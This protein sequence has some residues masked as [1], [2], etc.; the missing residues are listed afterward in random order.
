MPVP[1]LL[2]RE[3]VVDLSDAAA[4]HVLTLQA[5]HAS[6]Q[7]QRHYLF[8]CRQ[9]IDGFASMGI[10][11]DPMNLTTTNMRS[12]LAWYR[13]HVNQH[14]SRGGEVSVKIFAMRAKTFS[15]F[16]AR[17]QIIPDDLLR[18]LR[19]PRV[20]KILREPFTQTE[21][22][23]MWGACRGVTQPE[24][25]E[26]LFLLLLD[27]G[28]RIGEAASL[29][30]D[31]LR[32]DQRQV[33]VGADGKGRRERLVPIGDGSKRDGGRVLRALRNYL[34]VRKP[35]EP[36]TGRLFLSR[37]GRPMSA[38]AAS[39]AIQRLGELAGVHNPIPYRLRHTFCTWY[40]VAFPGDEIGLRQ[41]VGHL[42]HDVLA[43][44]V[45]Y[46]H[47]VIAD[48]AGRASLAEA[49]LGA[50]TARPP[51]PVQLRS[52][53]TDGPA[54]TNEQAHPAAFR[55]SPSEEDDDYLE[56][57]RAPQPNEDFNVARMSRKAER[58]LKGG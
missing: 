45:H 53:A 43:D 46:S 52:R 10:G 1:R 4:Y 25:E 18:T 3:Q 22:N 27:T 39:E 51:T 14:S 32:L 8:Y 11:L 41:I 29:K 26:A 40:L 37:E 24:R 17:E 30:I 49:W 57:N 38:G 55:R 7:T 56:A 47:S 50:G 48:R 2:G 16:M 44:Y 15:K 34:V 54:A 12:V 13:K 36:D 9:L 31:R 42:S 28:M 35:R 23:A 5:E 58:Y 20:T 19:V 21:V 6:E 33:I